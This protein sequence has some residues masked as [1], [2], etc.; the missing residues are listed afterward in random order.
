MPS[1]IKFYKVIKKISKKDSGFS[2]FSVL[3]IILLITSFSLGTAS[4]LFWYQ[5]QLSLS[6]GKQE[7]ETKAWKIYQELAKALL[8]DESPRSDSILDPLWKKTSQLQQLNPQLTIQLNDQS[9]K[10]NLNFVQ[11]RFLKRGSLKTLLKAQ[12]NRRDFIDFRDKSGPLMDIAS[13]DDFIK[14][15]DKLFTVYSYA[16]INTD[17]PN[18]LTK[19]FLLRTNP[20]SRDIIYQKIINL[21]L[22]KKILSQDDF[23][24]WCGVDYAKVFPLITAKALWN[25]HFLPKEILQAVLSYQKKQIP[26]WQNLYNQIMDLRENSE[27]SP[28]F[29]KTRLPQNKKHDY[30]IIHHYLGTETWFWKLEIR[31]NTQSRIFYFRKCLGKKKSVQLMGNFGKLK[32]HHLKPAH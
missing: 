2:S 17:Y 29:L 3:L 5:R 24:A 4:L 13:Y 16:N 23:H 10:I 8:D 32:L 19:L 18:E 28:D 6:S 1:P 27:I 7:F 26:G 15:T 30:R 14:I 11:Y 12:K 31:L 22:E 20:S 9:S 25:V 21:R